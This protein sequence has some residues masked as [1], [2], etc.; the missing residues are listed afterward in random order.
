MTA[1][2]ANQAR[3]FRNSFNW[4]CKHDICRDL[5][6]EKPASDAGKE[7]W[8]SFYVEF[9]SHL[10]ETIGAEAV[11]ATLDYFSKMR[12]RATLKTALQKAGLESAPKGKTAEA[13][14]VP[15]ADPRAILA[16][17]FAAGKITLEAFTAAIAALGA[18]AK[19][20]EPIEVEPIDL[21]A[22]GTSDLPF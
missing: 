7:A 1:T 2:T 12:N 16:S 5:G 19:T 14:A 8:K 21:D 6:I 13:P 10:E 9:A 17:A 3:F 22:E 18:S 15:V 4:N 11:K 20:V